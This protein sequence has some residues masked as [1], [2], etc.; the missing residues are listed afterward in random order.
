M[1]RHEDALSVRQE[2]VFLYRALNAGEQRQKKDLANALHGYGSTLSDLGRHEEALSV[3]QEAISL[4]HTLNID[5]VNH[6]HS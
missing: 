2:I 5:P 1:G 3:R 6:R 4:S